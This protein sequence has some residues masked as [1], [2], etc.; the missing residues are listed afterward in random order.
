MNK[1]KNAVTVKET[2]VE[3]TQP[4]KKKASITPKEAK[5]NKE[6]KK[7]MSAKKPITKKTSKKATAKKSVAKKLPAKSKIVKKAI[8]AA[9]PTKVS[10]RRS[11]ES[12]S[13]VTP[14]ILPKDAKV[15]STSPVYETMYIAYCLYKHGASYASEVV[16]VYTTQQLAEEVLEARKVYHAEQGREVLETS[17]GTVPVDNV[18]M[19]KSEPENVYALIEDLKQKQ[20]SDIYL[21]IGT[22]RKKDED[23]I[24][25]KH[26]IVADAFTS[27]A[28]NPDNVAYRLANAELYYTNQGYSNLHF[29]SYKVKDGVIS[30]DLLELNVITQ[31]VEYEQCSSLKDVLVGWL[32]NKL[33]TPLT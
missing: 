25:R 10:P 20:Q 32:T 18:N 21:I 19:A 22:G 30:K 7:S 9:S 11:S 33:Y 6:P 17:V 14:R 31:H 2:K 8:D 5:V 26:T 23:G 12:T 16:G 27:L 15:I 13:Q 29:Y 24:Y 1:S 4:P 28:N 3:A